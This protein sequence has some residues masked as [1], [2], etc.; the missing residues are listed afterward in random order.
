MASRA[1][2]WVSILSWYQSQASFSGAKKV[3]SSSVDVVY[4][5]VLFMHHPPF[6]TGMQAMDR[7]GLEGAERLERAVAPYENVERILCGHLHVSHVEAVETEG[8]PRLVVA[9]AGTATSTRGRGVP[10]Q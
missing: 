1:K 3:P 5:T 7:M 10:A 4:S 8:A 9:S 2:A 6:R